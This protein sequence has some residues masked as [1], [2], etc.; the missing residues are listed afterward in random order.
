ML[1]LVYNDE[2]FC[3]CGK[4]RRGLIGLSEGFVCGEKNCAS[5]T[6]E[7]VCWRDVQFVEFLLFLSALSLSLSKKQ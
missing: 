7:G 6:E 5:E 4:K 1:R 3:S 2:L